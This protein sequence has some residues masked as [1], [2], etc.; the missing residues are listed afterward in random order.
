[1]LRYVGKDAIVKN[2]SGGVYANLFG[3]CPPFQIDGNFGGGA[4]ISE[5]LLQSHQGY[6]ELLPA[7]PVEWGEGEVK[8]LCA[9]GGFEVSIKWKEGK[10]VAVS[11]LSKNGGNAQVKY[12]EKQIDIKTVAGGK[13]SLSE[14]VK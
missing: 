2:N 11:L 13:Y 14:L 4:G 8:G 9:R 5:M 3:A 12:K 6:I 1:M 10:L 7:I